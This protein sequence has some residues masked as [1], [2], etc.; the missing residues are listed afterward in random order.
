MMG[1]RHRGSVRR[2]AF[3]PLPPDG[4]RG[5]PLRNPL[6]HLDPHSHPAPVRFDDHVIPP[7]T[8]YLARRFRPESRPSAP[9]CALL[10]RSTERT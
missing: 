5:R 3:A 8:P 1:S 10:S 6:V 2:F 4:G 7:V 9:G